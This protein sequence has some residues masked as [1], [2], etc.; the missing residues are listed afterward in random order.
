MEIINKL[1]K[2]ECVQSLMKIYEVEP[3][4]DLLYEIWKKWNFKFCIEVNSEDDSKQRKIMRV[5]DEKLEEV[6]YL[7][8]VWRKNKGDPISGSLWENIAIEWKNF[9]ILAIL[10]LIRISWKIIN[11]VVVFARWKYKVNAS[12]LMAVE[13]FKSESFRTNYFL[14]DAHNANR[15]GLN[16]RAFPYN[17]VYWREN[18]V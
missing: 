8:F 10:T 9:V 13:Y 12:D 18:E 3:K 1:D 15:I 4:Y 6:V 2:S 11:P 5:R 16:C 7:W 14:D 17:F